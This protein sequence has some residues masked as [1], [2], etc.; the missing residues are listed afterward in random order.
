M[1]VRTFQAQASA[2]LPLGSPRPSIP[3]EP[4]RS[5]SPGMWEDDSLAA[6]TSVINL[7][8][9][10]FQPISFFALVLS[11]QHTGSQILFPH[12]TWQ[13]FADTPSVALDS[14]LLPS[15]DFPSPSLP[16]FR[17]TVDFS[18]G[19]S[20]CKAPVHKWIEATESQ[21][22]DQLNE[23][24][25]AVV[26]T[27][28]SWSGQPH[29]AFSS[30]LLG[31]QTARRTLSADMEHE[32]LTWSRC[33]SRKGGGSHQRYLVRVGSVLCWRGRKGDGSNLR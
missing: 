26:G 2:L 25:A 12:Q 9:L 18:S 15:M 5:P 21:V 10:G 4:L 27:I 24:L 19:T 31:W 20:S 8:D 28:P 13:M 29:W 23:G 14:D 30:W 32:G 11:T 33:K 22:S 17:R 16:T 7:L 1:I 6:A 3:R